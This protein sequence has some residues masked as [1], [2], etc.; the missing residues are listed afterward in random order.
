MRERH[1]WVFESSIRSV[2]QKGR[3]GDVAVIFDRKNRFLAVGLLDLE[4][5][6]RIRVLNVGS[7]ARVGEELIRERLTR[8]LAR[9]G[10]LLEDGAT[11]GF[12][13]VNG[14][15]DGLP[16]VVVDRYGE[17]VVAKLYS[18]A[19]ISRLHELVPA[20][21]SALQPP[22][23]VVLV[24]RTVADSP[25]CPDDFARGA[26]LVGDLE[27]GALSFLEAG[28]RFEA[29]PLDG[30]K[31][32]F[33]LDQRENRKRVQSLAGGAR[34]LNVFSYTGGFSLYAARG[35]A[36]AVTSVDVSGPALD[37]AERHFQLNRD[38]DRPGVD[39]VPHRAVRGDAFRVLEEMGTRG[40]RFDLVIVDPPAFAKAGKQTAGALAS[41]GKL[42]ELA[43]GVL[44]TGGVLVQA[45]CS[46]RVAPAEFFDA[47]H[48]AARRMGQRLVEIE[49]TGHPLD[50]PFR[51]PEGEYLKCLFA[52]AH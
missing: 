1:P 41:Y 39:E 9:R 47:V 8:A 15:G 44:E 7:P 19:W 32:G 22:E 52:Q 11:T 28:L 36:G 24:S 5:P 49:R 37:Q 30:H 21:T 12:R 10:S 40:E 25:H 13:V 18:A 4:S 17:G 33:Y 48:L 3:T 23:V 45:S 35:G 29:H 50:H 31:T 26:V 42:T 27:G 20:I 34:V 43:L 46:A 2:S 16:G 38:A 6:I 14:A 51:H